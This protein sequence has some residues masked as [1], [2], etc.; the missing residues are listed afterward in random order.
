MNA[1][2]CK[3]SLIHIKNNNLTH[4]TVSGVGKIR[5]VPDMMVRTKQVGIHYKNPGDEI[6]KE[7]IIHD[8][9]FAEV[10]FNSSVNTLISIIR[11][12]SPP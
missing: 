11:V 1:H 9:Q 5:L 6:G 10:S 3:I 4:H 12:S 7:I 8:P 2:M